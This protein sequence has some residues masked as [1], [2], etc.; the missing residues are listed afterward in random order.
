MGNE[1]YHIYDKIFKKILT[2]SSKAVINLINGL[3]QTNHS[4]ENTVT[5]H[6]TESQDNEL[7]RTLADTILTVNEKFV[8]HMEAQMEKDDDIVFRVFDYGC[9]YA[10]KIEAEAEALL[11]NCSFHSRQSFICMPETIS[12]IHIR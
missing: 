9:G 11:V 8:Y 5:Y 1:L 7:R 6:W 12:R 2:L 4:I 10:E 3:F